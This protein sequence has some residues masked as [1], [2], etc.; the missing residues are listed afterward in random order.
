M[1]AMVLGAG[2]MLGHDLVATA[3]PGATLFPFTRAELDITATKSL[4]VAVADVRPDV[5]INAAAYTAVDRAESEAAHCFRV[6]AE[7]VGELGRIAAHAGA[8]VVQFSTDYVFDGT[9]SDPYEE[10]SPTH[11]IN[12][13][14][15]SK[16]AG[17][18]AL[19]QS[20]AR[21]LII[22]TQWL[23]GVHGKSFPRTMWERA[24]AGATTKVVGDQTGRPTYSRDLARSVWA[25][26]ER[27]A[28][29]VLHVANRGKATWFDLAAH[30]FACAGR[31]D[32]LTACVS[33]DYPT[34]AQRPRYSVL[35]TTRFER[36]IGAGLPDWPA[37]VDAFLQSCNVPSALERAHVRRG[38]E[39]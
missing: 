36:M 24:K 8:Q 29:G 2:G 25:L 1:R 20:Q 13:Y 4:T 3:P 27:A 6:N 18:T 7:A 32:L 30:I 37:A 10:E 22:R 9:S 16:L 17:E 14:G 23:F 35:D 11:P 33:A 31:S 12:T 15:A 34:A 26:T 21:F 38:G 28:F 5:I 19:T 39:F